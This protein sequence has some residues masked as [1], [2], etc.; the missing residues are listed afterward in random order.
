VK[1]GSRRRGG[2]RR[3]GN[4]LQVYV[5]VHSGP[6]GLKTCA[7][8][9]ETESS[10]LQDWIDDTFRDYRRKHPRGTPGTLTRDVET[11]LKLLVDRPG[12]Q[13][14]RAFQLAWWCDQ[15]GARARW[16]L[17]PVELE[18]ALNTLTAAGAAASTVKKYRT[19][20][21]HLFTKLDGKRHGNALRDVPP[22]REPDPLPKAIPYPIIDAIFAAMPD[23]RYARSLTIDQARALQQKARRPDASYAALAREYDVSETMVRKIAVNRH[24]PRH[25]VPSQSKAR[26]RMMA[27]LGW[28]PAM[29][30]AFDPGDYDPETPSIIARGRKKGGG[31]RAVRQK[32]T[33]DGV[34]AVEALLAAEAY[35][36]LLPSG[37]RSAFSMS[38][39]DRLFRRGIDR[40]CDELEATLETTAIGQRL[41]LEL[42]AA[43]PYW[44][45]HSFLT[46]AQLATGNINA[47]QGLAVHSD[48]RMTR[49]YTLAAVTPELAHAADLLTA[50]WSGQ[51]TGNQSRGE[52][53]RTGQN[54]P[55][56]ASGAAAGSGANFR[57]KP[58]K[59]AKK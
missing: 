29:I 55:K 8:P 36:R 42:A 44:L 21:Y 35:D 50:R 30:R 10:K 18:T 43:T 38:S 5:R 33:P 11:Y 45:R 31:S 27:Y 52:M 20:L 32:L 47:T 28:A 37:R 19:A 1:R 59:I 12:L 57:A 41:R 24:G 48:A 51:R 34:S 2:W 25:D 56:T 9:V 16:S 23:R 40:L 4:K 46:E 17:Q 14:D 53:S 54:W 26:L 58:R 7:F 15:F 39:L 49:R 6:G 22:P 3:K 13:R